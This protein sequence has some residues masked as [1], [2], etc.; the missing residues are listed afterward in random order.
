MDFRVY[1]SNL[2]LLACFTK[3]S[4]VSESAQMMM[5]SCRLVR[6]SWIVL[7]GSALSHWWGQRGWLGAMVS[8]GGG[9]RCSRGA[10]EGNGRFC[11]WDTDR[12]Q[13]SLD[14]LGA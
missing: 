12:R 8:G 5:V 3:S 14:T 4:M 2:L 9:G 7:G 10:V 11:A 13:G 6:G 1:I